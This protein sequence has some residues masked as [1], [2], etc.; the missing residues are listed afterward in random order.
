MCGNVL[1]PCNSISFFFLNILK[2]LDDK[3]PTLARPGSPGDQDWLALVLWPESMKCFVMV[4]KTQQLCFSLHVSAVEK[5]IVLWRRLHRFSPHKSSLRLR[6]SSTTLAFN[7]SLFHIL[8]PVSDP[9]NFRAT[10]PSF[11]MDV[12]LLYITMEDP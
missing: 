2:F 4:S 7:H 11:S 8:I 3:L 10:L 1:L 9:T 5:Y 6:Q 12:P